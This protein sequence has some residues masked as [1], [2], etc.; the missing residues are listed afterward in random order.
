SIQADQSISFQ[1]MRQK[2][3]NFVEIV[4]QDPAVENVTAYTGGGAR[5]RGFMF[6]ALKPLAQRDASAEQVITR[7]R[8]RLAREPGA[9][10]FLVPVSDI[11]A[12]GRSSGAQYQFTLQ[13][14]DLDL[15]RTWEPRV[16]RAL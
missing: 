5:N 15:L 11:R 13:A 1:A 12:G 7:L 4:R 14:D 2:V 10:L 6:V 8:A 16:R 3:A 9:S